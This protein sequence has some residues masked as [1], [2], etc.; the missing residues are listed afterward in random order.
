MPLLNEPI[1]RI[2]SIVRK[3]FLFEFFVPC[4][5]GHTLFTLL[6]WSRSLQNMLA[7]DFV[8][9]LLGC[10]TG[11]VFG[12]GYR[13]SSARLWDCSWKSLSGADC[14]EFDRTGVVDCRVVDHAR[15]VGD[16]EI[17]RLVFGYYNSP[18]AAK[19]NDKCEAEEN[20]LVHLAARLVGNWP[21]RRFV[22]GVVETVLGIRQGRSRGPSRKL[23]KDIE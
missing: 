11:A 23:C 19:R 1:S 7:V 22:G 12:Y 3:F 13:R 10:A 4:L 18:G 21:F 17:S 20:V 5:G 2:S 6:V 8:E 15:R 9:V 14:P 16:G